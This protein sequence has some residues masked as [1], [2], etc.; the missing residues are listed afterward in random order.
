M[1][2]IPQGF[3]ESSP[4]VFTRKPALGVTQSEPESKLHDQIIAYCRERKWYYVHSRM[5]RA[6]THAKGVPD[7][8]IATDSGETLWIECKRKGAKP[9]VEQLGANQWLKSL[10][11]RAHIVW[12]F[13]E[14]KQFVETRYTTT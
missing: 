5:D 14:F 12:T 10:R 11:Q 13:D 3:Y 1:S 9:S 4:G 7:F 2:A 8:I 6:T